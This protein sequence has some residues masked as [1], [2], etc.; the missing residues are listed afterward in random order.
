MFFLHDS[1]FNVFGARC[2]YLKIHLLSE[3]FRGLFPHMMIQDRLDHDS[4]Y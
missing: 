4:L 2:Y 1:S 3:F